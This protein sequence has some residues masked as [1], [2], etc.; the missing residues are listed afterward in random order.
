MTLRT[1]HLALIAV[2]AILLIALLTRQGVSPG[3]S[4][5]VDGTTAFVNGT[6]TGHDMGAVR[7]LLKEHPQVE[8][9]VFETM[10]GTRDMTSNYRLARSIRRAGLSTEVTPDSRI[11]SGAVD[12]FLA[13]TRRT[14]A[15]G[16]MIGVHSWG[17][18]GYDS[19]DVVWDQHRSMSRAFLSDMGVDP[20]FYD[21]RNRAAGAESIHWLS[22]AEVARWGVATEPRDCGGRN[23]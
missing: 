9:L 19:G 5:R 13:G 7:D 22:D 4:F 18:L 16:A 15:C 2:A 6:T 14:V 21:F 3:L 23:G 11:A 12:L 17:S 8:H 1:E 20:D 10:P